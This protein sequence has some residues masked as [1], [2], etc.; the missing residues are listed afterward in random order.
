VSHNPHADPNP[1]QVATEQEQCFALKLKGYSVR[2]IAAETGMSK[3]T[4]QR[5]LDS[6]YAELVQPVAAEA[7]AI[8]IERYDA[9]LKQLEDKAQAMA[10]SSLGITLDELCKVT[11][12]KTRV[13]ERRARLMGLDAPI[14]VEA[15]GELR[16]VVEGL[17][18]EALR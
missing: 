9:W 18:S 12:T 7:R 13:A 3:T 8:E 15:R 11:A 6:A 14:A 10:S 1:A 5:R 16:V 4:V 17:D 2:A